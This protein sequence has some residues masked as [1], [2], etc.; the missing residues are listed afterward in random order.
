MSKDSPDY[1]RLSLAAAMELG[2]VKGLFYRGARLHCINL[3]QTYGDGC[4]ANCAFC[5]LSR[6]RTGLYP[7]K[8]FIRVEWP[9]K[10]T[11]EIIERLQ[12]VQEG[13]VVQRVCLSM[14]THKRALDDSLTLLKRLSAETT[15]PLSAL[16]S[17]TVMKTD[18]L[19][20]LKEAGAERVGV[21][22]DCATRELFDRHRG[23]GVRG[24]H[25]WD[26]YWQ[27]YEASAKVFGEMMTGVHLICGVGETE[28]ELTRAFQKARD[29]GGYTHLFS[30]FPEAGSGL[31]QTLP[32]LIPV[33]RRIQLA[34]YLID[35]GLT[36]F[37][38]L[39]FDDQDRIV[40][41]GVGQATL[42]RAIELGQCFMTSGCPGETME[43]ACNR[44][45]AN[46]RPGP[47]IRNYPFALNDEDKNLCR[48]QLWADMEEGGQRA[49][50]ARA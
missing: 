44:P 32:P 47:E 31:A 2:F 6:E 17:P 39:S 22:I 45:F 14:V 35:H 20:R 8:K 26:H 34:R 16:I 9:T 25:N 24:P 10:S 43:A 36:G 1:L 4:R 48:A 12:E 15:L 23:K 21:A 3:L 49:G 38:D 11:E 37:A 13:P 29:L 19:K 40:D 28:K 27:I 30:F 42:D 46:E 7:E 5:G 33:Y 18:D 50:A 41:F